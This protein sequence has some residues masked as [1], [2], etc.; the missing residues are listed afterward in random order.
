MPRNERDAKDVE[1]QVVYG[2]VCLSSL[3]ALIDGQNNNSYSCQLCTRPVYAKCKACEKSNP[4]HNSECHAEFGACGHVFHHHCLKKKKAPNNG[5]AADWGNGLSPNIRRPGSTQ[6]TLNQPPLKCPNQACRK[7]WVVRPMEASCKPIQKKDQDKVMAFA[8]GCNGG[9]GRGKTINTYKSVSFGETVAQLTE[10]LERDHVDERAKLR[11]M[12]QN[13]YKRG[14]ELRRFP[15]SATAAAGPSEAT[16]KIAKESLDALTGRLQTAE[17]EKLASEAMDWKRAAQEEKERHAASQLAMEDMQQEHAL[18]TEHVALLEARVRAGAQES[19]AKAAEAA[20]AAARVQNGGNGVAGGGSSSSTPATSATAMSAHQVIEDIRKGK[21]L[22]VEVP[23]NM[24]ES[25]ENL[26]GMCG[27]GLEKLSKDLYNHESHFFN[28]LLQNCDDN[29]Y[30]EGCSPSVK[31]IVTNAAVVLLNNELGFSAADV[32]SLCDLGASTKMDVSSAIGRKGIGFKSVFMVSDMPHVIS[33]EWS[34]KFDVEKNGLFG[35]VSPEWVS[36]AEVQTMLPAGIK[37]DMLAGSTTCLYMPRK[38]VMDLQIAERFQ[39]ATL[40]FLRKINRLCIEEGG[41]QRVVEIRVDRKMDVDP[42]KQAGAKK[43]RQEKKRKK[44]APTQRQTQVLRTSAGGDAMDEGGDEAPA[45]AAGLPASFGTCVLEETTVID[46][47]AATAGGGVESET[48][49]TFR[50]FRRTN[51]PLP[52]HLGGGSTEIVLAFPEYNGRDGEGGSGMPLQNFH[53]YLPVTSCGFP[54]VLNANWELTSSRQDVHQDSPYNIFLRDAVAPTLLAALDSCD[55][56]KQQVG[57]I[58]AASSVTSG[59][60]RPVLK[61]V[62]ENLRD[63]PCL[64]TESGRWAC[65]ADVFRRGKHATTGLIS[66]AAVMATFQSV[67]PPPERTPPKMNTVME[68]VHHSMD[69][70]AEKLDSKLFGVD[71]MMEVVRQRIAETGSF[72]PEGLDD[73]CA[74]TAS[75]YSFFYTGH[76]DVSQLFELPIFEVKVGSKALIAEA[77]SAF[78]TDDSKLWFA[79]L[80]R[81]KELAKE[82]KKSNDTMILDQAKLRLLVHARPG[83]GIAYDEC[84]GVTMVT[85]KTKIPVLALIAREAFLKVIGENPP[86]TT[87]IAALK[88]GSIHT[89][90]PDGCDYLV[91]HGLIKVLA[92][93]PALSSK[94]MADQN[95]LKFLDMLNIVSATHTEIMEMVIDQHATDSITSVD[96]CWAGLK[97]VKDHLWE[98]IDD[99][100]VKEGAETIR[101]SLSS[102]LYAPTPTG[103]LVSIR[104]LS[105]NGYFGIACPCS[106]QQQ[107]HEHEAPAWILADDVGF[108]LDP[109]SHDERRPSYDPPKTAVGKSPALMNAA[110][111]VV[112]TAPASLG[113]SSGSPASWFSFFVEMGA[114][115]HSHSCAQPEYWAGTSSET[116]AICMQSLPRVPSDSQQTLD[117]VEMPC[118][119]AFH[120]HCLQRWEAQKMRQYQPLACPLCRTVATMPTSE[121]KM[122]EFD[123]R[124][125][126]FSTAVSDVIGQLTD[127]RFAAENVSEMKTLKDALKRMAADAQS[128]EAIKSAVV[129]S[130]L[131]P[132]SLGDCFLSDQDGM[133]ALLP[134]IALPHGHAMSPEVSELLKSLGASVTNTIDGL[135]HASAVMKQ[136]VF[137]SADLRSSPPTRHLSAFAVLYLEMERHLGRG[138]DGFSPILENELTWVDPNVARV[139]EFFKKNESIFCG[140]VT[141]FHTSADV[142]WSGNRDVAKLLGK[143][144]LVDCYGASLKPFFVDTLKLKS[145]GTEGCWD[146]LKL[147]SQQAGVDYGNPAGCAKLRA[148]VR[149]LYLELEKWAKKVKGPSWHGNPASAYFLCHDTANHVLRVVAGSNDAPIFYN[150]EPYTYDICRDKI[151]FWLDLTVL[152]DDMKHLKRR[153]TQEGPSIQT[154]KILKLSSCV[155]SRGNLTIADPTYQ[156]TEWTRRVRDFC[157]SVALEHCGGSEQCQELALSLSIYRSPSISMKVVIN[158]KPKVTKPAHGFLAAYAVL[159]GL[160][161]ETPRL[162]AADK[163][164]DDVDKPSFIEC[165]KEYHYITD[166]NTTRII[167]QGT[168][169]E[170]SRRSQRSDLECQNIAEGVTQFLW[171]FWQASSRSMLQWMVQSFLLK[172]AGLPSKPLRIHDTEEGTSSYGSFSRGFGGGHSGHHNSGNGFHFPAGSAPLNWN[173]PEGAPALGRA[174]SGSGAAKHARVERPAAPPPGMTVDMLWQQLRAHD[175]AKATQEHQLLATQNR[176]LAMERKREEEFKANK[177]MLAKLKAE[178]DGAANAPRGTKRA[179][180]VLDKEDDDEDED[181]D[182]E[183]VSDTAALAAAPSVATAAASAAVTALSKTSSSR[184]MRPGKTAG[185]GAAGSAAPGI[186]TPPKKTAKTKKKASSAIAA[187]VAKATKAAAVTSKLATKKNRTRTRTPAG[188]AATAAAAANPAKAKAKATPKAKAN[189]KAKPNAK[190]TT[191]T[192]TAVTKSSKKRKASSGGASAGTGA[193][194]DGDDDIDDFE[195]KPPTKKKTK[196]QKKTT[197]AAAAAMTKTKTKKMKKGSSAN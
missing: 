61:A 85:S 103:C 2:L 68:F 27:R 47:R 187:K 66:N 83:T 146:A 158:K 192:M 76:V 15:F 1:G 161:E 18:L 53:A 67:P 135:L 99:P 55:E 185:G 70:M 182:E 84:I 131:G 48:S 86:A 147:L 153:I 63:T 107:P 154:F 40:I 11:E 197:T 44:S 188:K 90:L 65:P 77:G 31:I 10:E 118:H 75:L 45:V 115:L 124:F 137:D 79:L 193:T 82:H 54:F 129:P 168:D 116:C 22:D 102:T 97:F 120:K 117:V 179:A 93:V 111:A 169:S 43:K 29:K 92:H 123:K 166:N 108:P 121:M 160:V 190:A 94:D 41:V 9:G 37:D 24:K 172:K 21:L 81:R 119:H 64:K 164:D 96:S 23:E 132:T 25:V 145:I 20:A 189:P 69:A 109:P 62:I 134:E 42:A 194:D 175:H 52:Q 170:Q 56:L 19:A 39:P 32:R 162:V 95:A 150:D 13:K 143:R 183:K 4:G 50:V 163:E 89:G 167:A 98:Y 57:E 26:R 8:A 151:P 113:G 17:L 12:L 141:A 101:E 110:D 144:T 130:T 3:A 114:K 105:V 196:T 155:E 60:W 35:Y 88:E 106:Q 156:D 148:D 142:L 157:S 174:G 14:V 112:G 186:E 28:E 195:T 59:F 51:I 49:T 6:S 177:A 127:R 173:V 139:T 165:I 104:A 73:V 159:P 180:H 191:K 184:K 133:K 126:A 58:L 91:S 30:A 71:D 80:Q 136:V 138:M 7:P 178:L 100:S 72:L 149:K 140:S 122:V 152:S 176:L 46:T 38:R 181:E 5:N 125:E 171:P 16:I 34:F 74:W 36:P 33:G 87:C 128:Q 78:D